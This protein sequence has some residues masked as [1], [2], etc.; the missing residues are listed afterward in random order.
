MKIFLMYQINKFKILVF[1]VFKFLKSLPKGKVVS[2]GMIVKKFGIANPR[3]VGWILR[4]NERSDEIPCY[5]V[6]RADGRLAK[7]YKFGGAKGQ[8]KR[9]VADGVKFKGGRIVTKFNF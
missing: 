3:N 1:S 7:G 5:K 8:K 6:V 2:Y 4:Q 9:L